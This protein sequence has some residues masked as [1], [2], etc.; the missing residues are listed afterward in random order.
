MPNGHTDLERRVSKIEVQMER[1][2]ADIES[3]KGTRARVNGEITTRLSHIEDKQ[4]QRGEKF[5]DRM[6]KLEVRVAMFMGGLAAIE[7]ALK[8]IK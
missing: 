4:D 1:F 2:I 3:E 5:D 6:R 7:I 8:F